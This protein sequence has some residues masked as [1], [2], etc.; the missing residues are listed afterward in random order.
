VNLSVGPFEHEV[1]AGGL[2]CR[3]GAMYVIRWAR[4]PLIARHDYARRWLQTVADLG[5]ARNTVEAY[6]RAV[7]E[8]ICFTRSLGVT[9]DGANMWPRMF[10][11]C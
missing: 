7:E 5:H 4:C 6:G 3:E 9:P 1:A 2:A 10:D 8:Y 11:R